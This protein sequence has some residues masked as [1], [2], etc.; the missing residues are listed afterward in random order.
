MEKKEIEKK[1]NKKE[2]FIEEEFEGRKVIILVLIVLLIVVGMIV[3]PKLLNNGPDTSST[4]EPETSTQKPEENKETST[5]KEEADEEV[6]VASYYYETVK[7]NFGNTIVKRKKVLSN[8]SDFKLPEIPSKEGYRFKRFI[9]K[10]NNSK[11]EVVV[12]AEFIKIWT[13]TIYDGEDIINTFVIDDNTTLSDT[14]K[15]AVVK[16]NYTLIG[17]YYDEDFTHEYVSGAIEENINLYS[18]WMSNPKI[19]KQTYTSNIYPSIIQNDLVVDVIDFNVKLSG[20]VGHATNEELT[21]WEFTEDTHILPLYIKAP[22]EA[23]ITWESKTFNG[24]TE[25][26][27]IDGT[28]DEEYILGVNGTETGTPNDLVITYT[29]TE[30]VS[31][32]YTYKFDIT[33]LELLPEVGTEYNITYVLNNQAEI[34]DVVNPNATTTYVYGTGSTLVDATTETIGYVFVGWY[35]DS[36]Y[37]NKVTEISAGMYG[38][39]ILYSR[40]EINY[41]IN[42]ENI[43]GATNNN[44][45][46]YTEDL[47]QVMLVNP[48]KSGYTFTGWKLIDENGES[49]T[50]ITPIKASNYASNNII[51]LY[52][53]WEVIEY[54]LTFNKNIPTSLTAPVGGDADPNITDSIPSDIVVDVTDGEVE[55]PDLTNVIVEMPCGTTQE[56]QLTGWAQESNSVTG[57]NTYTLDVED[58]NEDN[59]VEFYGVWET[60]QA[61]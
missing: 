54:T 39:I 9:V 28:A 15:N 6:A 46:T 5:E 34:T 33:K 44:V 38:D 4:L 47:G 16:N 32:T 43:E 45:S 2:Q 59:K 1:E 26:I 52:A 31:Y 3:G 57:E 12:T 35:T 8:Y 40:F 25:L 36:T 24:T 55:L 19:I 14:N 27:S 51:T 60:Y 48:E 29:T 21:G 22:V 13:V 30:D 61:E 18:R 17:I 11:T 7:D 58:A 10:W 20:K 49:V 42:Y 56:Y 41:I 50:S 53:T 37:T 23:G